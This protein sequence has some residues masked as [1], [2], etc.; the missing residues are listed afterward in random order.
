ME[1]QQKF[2]HN[3]KNGGL[4]FSAMIVIYLFLILFLSPVVEVIFEKDSTAYVLASSTFS[5]LSMLAVIL[6]KIVADKGCEKKPLFSFN[7]FKWQYSILAVCLCLGMLF[8]LGFLNQV[9]ANVL[10]GLKLN[11]SNGTTFVIDTP[12]K[13]VAFI[14]FIAVLPA[15]V[16]EMFFRGILL[17][18]LKDSKPV[19]AVLTVAFCFSL[20][21]CSATQFVYQFIFGALLCLIAIGAKSIIPCIIAH[22]LN[23]FII[24]LFEYVKFNVNLLNPL[25][26][27]CGCAVLA[28]SV[29]LI[30]TAL[31]KL[32]QKSGCESVKTFYLPYGVLGLG[33]CVALLIGSL[34]VVG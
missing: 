23:N 31:K 8:G 21:H 6:I 16:E 3:Q 2:P 1:K 10:T 12:I 13:F 22:F 18:S 30:I 14:F 29:V 17:N 28:V 7:A 5:I 25:I 32:N 20:Y 9:V 24:L 33:A 27:A 26:I 19:Q 4:A 15:V 34:F 11:V